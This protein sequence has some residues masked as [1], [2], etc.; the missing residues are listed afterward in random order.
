MT[1]VA[2]LYEKEKEE[3]VAK[4]EKEK[5][6]EIARSLLEI[7]APEVVAEKTGLTIDEV[8]QLKKN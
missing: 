4:A 2:R 1:K 8:K 3:A 6:I 7:L 5:A